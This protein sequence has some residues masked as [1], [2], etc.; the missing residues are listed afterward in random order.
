MVSLV[1]QYKSMMNEQFPNGK[2]HCGVLLHE[3]VMT[4]KMEYQPPSA[5]MCGRC[6]RRWAEKK[7]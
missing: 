7:E 6:G 4:G 3:T 1:E 5:P 2:C